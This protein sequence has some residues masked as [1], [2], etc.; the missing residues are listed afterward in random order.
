M[1]K[2]DKRTKAYK[3]YVKNL[4]KKSKGLGDTVEKITKA[5]GIKKAVTWAL[6]EDCGCDERKDSLNKL[7]PYNRSECLTE[8]EYTFVKS[9]EPFHRESYARHEVVRIVQ[10]SNRIFHRKDN[11]G[12]SCGSCVKGM[13]VNLKTILD[14]YSK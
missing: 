13:L 5:T 3:E 2:L 11:P 7:F 9:L 10:I 1:T 12:T 14:E 4:E 8:D 6:G